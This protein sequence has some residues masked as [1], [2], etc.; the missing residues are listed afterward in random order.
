MVAPKASPS[1]IA[2]LRSSG[3]R[4]GVPAT[5]LVR[6]T[7]LDDLRDELRAERAESVEFAERVSLGAGRITAAASAGSRMAVVN[8]AGKLSYFASRFLRQR[9]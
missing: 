9:A 5:V 2:A 6:R 4:R 7:Q 3:G 1:P 8:E